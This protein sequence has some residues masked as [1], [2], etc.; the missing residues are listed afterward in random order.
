VLPL[1]SNV[2]AIAE[3]LFHYVDAAFVS[4]VKEKAG[5]FI[6]AGHNYGQGS[7]REHAAMCPMYFGVK[8]I[9]ARS[10]A[11]IH[12]DNLIN[13]AVL[14]L[15]FVQEGD[16]DT[17]HPEHR[18]EIQHLRQLLMDGATLIPVHNHTTQTTIHTSLE[19]SPRQRQILLAGGLLRFVGKESTV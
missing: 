9:L 2:P 1:R 13:F 10:F 16:Y 6:V 15:T 4:R 19:I 17:L 18:L 3:Y 8:A 7:S 12:R 14:P 11:R 5:G